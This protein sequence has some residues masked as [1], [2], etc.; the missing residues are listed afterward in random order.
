M[1]RCTGSVCYLLHDCAGTLDELPL[2]EAVSG[3]ELQSSSLL[4]QVDAAMAQL[5]DPGLYLVAHL[6]KAQQGVATLACTGLPTLTNQY[7]WMYKS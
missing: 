3:A 4:D 6:K 7:R 5:L 2:G 1:D